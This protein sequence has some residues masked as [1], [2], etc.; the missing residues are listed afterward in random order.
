MVNKVGR[1]LKN[2][3]T[4]QMHLYDNLTRFIG[5]K[6][7]NTGA[8]FNFLLE[9]LLED[10]GSRKGFVFTLPEVLRSF[11]LSLKIDSSGTSHLFDGNLDVY[12][13][14]KAGSWIKTA[15]QNKILVFNNESSL[16]S[17]NEDEK[18]SEIIYRFCS[19]PIIVDEKI[20]YVLIVAD[21][22]T[23]YD[24]YDIAYLE[25]LTVP[26]SR[27]VEM[28][29]NSQ[30][31][32]RD[33]ERAEQSEQRKISYLTNIA[34][35]IKTPVNAIIGF[36]GLLKESAN[37]PETHQKFL[38][39]IL[40]SSNNL[41]SIINSVAEISNFESG[42]ITIIEKEFNVTELISEVYEMLLDEASKRKLRFRT[43]VGIS[44]T[45]SLLIADREKL[46][47]VLLNLISNSLKF[48]YTG[49]IVFGYKVP[50]E[51]M[52]F[53]VSD[54]GT[55]IADEN[56]HLV[57]NHFFQ[58]GDSLSKSFKGTGL[59]LTLSKG[60]VEK[61]GGHIWFNSTE[62]KGSTFYFSVPF[63]QIS[64]S[65]AKKEQKGAGNIDGEK[66]SKVVLVAEDDHLNF[67][68]IKNFLSKLDVEIVRA[69]NGKE[70]VEICSA[71]NVD[72][73][74]MDIRMPVMDGYTATRLIRESYPDQII[75]AQ[76]AYT[77][78]RQTA[79][80]N[81]CTDFIA[82]PFGKQ[83]LISLVDSYL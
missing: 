30:E 65:L 81:G 68:L 72:L 61:M 69:E 9:H 62:G 64:H 40:E 25:L 45:E 15:E 51:F 74:L 73:V 79:L 50:G 29:L 38:D 43:E 33:K 16:F 39:I 26:L 8:Y 28:I 71:K 18:L 56:K 7:K 27:I 46:K 59:G 31:M 77:N 19:I 48:T 21:K 44:E 57:Y 2:D 47:Q 76:T 52:E 58:A 75:I 35:E 37:L 70:A 24:E 6:T 80:L 67:S 12:D 78:D 63:K 23:D 66:R 49:E 54:T 41:V 22:E 42:L 17:F 83:Q 32:I 55:G 82:K 20:R 34:H 10:T 1:T 5:Y 4:G 11:K 3:L 13:I 36:S 14:N 53:F 60:Y